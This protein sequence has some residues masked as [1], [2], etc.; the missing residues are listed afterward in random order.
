MKKIYVLLLILLSVLF[1]TGCGQK[2]EEN[3]ELQVAGRE[4]YFFNINVSSEIKN[5]TWGSVMTFIIKVTPKTF[6][7]K[8]N[9]ANDME[10][11]I[12]YSYTNRETGKFISDASMTIDVEYDPNGYGYEEDSLSSNAENVILLSYEASVSSWETATT[13]LNESDG[14]KITINQSNVLEYIKFDHKFYHD[15]G[16]GG[17]PGRIDFSSTINPTQH[18]WYEIDEIFLLATIEFEISY[19]CNNYL[20]TCDAYNRTSFSLTFS[21]YKTGGLDSSIDGGVDRHTLAGIC[22]HGINEKTLEVS[23]RIVSAEGYYIIKS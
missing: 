18:A 7:Y 9:A 6:K 11:K 14:N 22:D 23:Y 20:N 15:K 17:S 10:V 12:R 16:G 1:L 5:K 4:D 13:R 21:F 8:F 3:K 2:E 19:R